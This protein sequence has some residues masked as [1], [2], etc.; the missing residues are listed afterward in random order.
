[1]AQQT[2]RHSHS[3]AMAA[4]HDPVSGSDASNFAQRHKHEAFGR[5]A[6]HLGEQR[7]ARGTGHYITKLTQRGYG[8]F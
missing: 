2:L 8:T 3:K 4:S 7:T 5:K 6:H 1:M